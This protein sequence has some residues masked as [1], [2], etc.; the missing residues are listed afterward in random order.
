MGLWQRHGLHGTELGYPL[1][2]LTQLRGL[3]RLGKLRRWA[4]QTQLRTEA[5]RGIEWSSGL[6]K[7]AS[8]QPVELRCGGLV[9]SPGHISP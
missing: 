4:T 6:V 1:G 2:R 5:S 9:P 7:G 8:H 3:F